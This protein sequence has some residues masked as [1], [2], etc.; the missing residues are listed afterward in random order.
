MKLKK[1]TIQVGNFPEITH[2]GSE[3]ASEKARKRL[4]D[5][6]TIKP[7]PYENCAV[8]KPSVLKLP[9][10]NEDLK[11]VWDSNPLSTW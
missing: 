10:S 8:R 3:A 11:K 7:A 4:K 5:A 2:W 9:I 6:M 1:H